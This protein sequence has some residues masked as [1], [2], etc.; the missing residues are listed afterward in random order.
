[1]STSEYLIKVMK[2][3]FA[4]LKSSLKI[5]NH[6]QG[7]FQTEVAVLPMIQKSSEICVQHRN[8]L[9][10]AQSKLTLAKSTSKHNS[11]RNYRLPPLLNYVLLARE[12]LTNLT[13]R[14]NA[15]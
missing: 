13:V 7:L 10:N 5:S 1:M 6:R 15:A 9:E 12:H 8:G 2:C 3:S 11:Q 4:I 14:V